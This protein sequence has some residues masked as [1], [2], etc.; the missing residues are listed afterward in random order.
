M[1]RQEAAAQYQKALKQGR[2]TY[3][4]CVLHGRYPYP[5]ILDD[6]LDD[7]MVAG[8]VDLGV[9]NIPMDKIVGTRTL[10]RRSAFAADFMPLLDVNTEFGM[11]WV[12]LC[13]DHLGDEGIRDPIRCYEYLGRFYVQEGNKR[14][15][16]LKSFGAPV[17]ASYVIRAIPKWSEDPEVR[18]YYDFLEAYR[19]TGLYQVAFTRPGSF[20]KLQVALGF[21]PD[22]DWTQ[23]EQRKFLAGLTWFSEAFDKAG[24]KELPI[25][26]ADA[27]LVWLKVYPFSQLSASRAELLKT[28]QGL[29]ADIKGAAEEEPISVTTEDADEPP[30]TGLLG[31]IF[32]PA[33]PSHL[34]VAFIHQYRPKESNWI[35]AHDLGREYLEAVLE[36]EVTVQTMSGVGSG[37]EAEQAMEAAIENGAKVVFATTASLI[38]ACRKA[39]AQHPDVRVLNCAISMPYAG[40]RTY[41]SRVYE[42]KFITGAIAGAMSQSG[43]IGYVAEGPIF[44]VPAS[45]NAFALGVQM[46]NPQAKILLKWDCLE[47]DPVAELKREG[48][49]LLSNRDVPTPDKMQAPW[50]LC[51]VG[52]DG[53]TCLCS[54]Y[55]HWGH[56]YVKLVRSIFSGEWDALGAREGRAVNYWW[57]MHS[58]TTGVLLSEQ[59]PPGVAQLAECLRQG[60]IGGSIVPFGRKIF[61]Q[62]GTM[63]NDGTQW[64]TP[65]EILRMD[66]LC[67]CVEGHIP[68]YEELREEAKPLVRLQG[69]YRDWLRPEKEGP[70]L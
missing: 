67:D 23:D 8:R 49:T 36:D 41:Y 40:V 56:F 65:E 70:I 7:A 2:K 13:Q 53:L 14:V 15:S 22:H 47:G 21:D 1:S 32:K 45:I 4:D 17:V 43:R 28:V 60:L 31:K 57:G 59:V 33:Q 68:A 3:K 50:G 69:V 6:I 55:W 35:R 62:D 11:K 52:A 66:W 48:V 25:T 18:A 38:G 64:L 9:V 42:S 44:G 61:S 27:L 12:S 20:D 16:V 24:G 29:W 19:H 26:P 51:R 10:G 30:A 63:Q 5:Q 39:A 37:D 58:Q 34:N 46:T 54:A